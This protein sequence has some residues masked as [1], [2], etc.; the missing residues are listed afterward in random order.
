M[1]Y[2]VHS[3]ACNVINTNINM[4]TNTNAPSS[5]SIS[6]YSSSLWETKEPPRVECSQHIATKEWVVK[7]IAQA[8]CGDILAAEYVVL[9]VLSRLYSRE[10]GSLLLGSLSLSLCGCEQGDARV[11]AFKAVL[12]EI[13]PLCVQV[14]PVTD[15]RH[16]SVLCNTV[17]QIELLSFLLCVRYQQ[18]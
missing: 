12:S 4:N 6:Q 18:I 7:R 16:C 10:D 13:V 2:P 1:L 8:L 3:K 5:S 11:A 17:A 9:A 14:R 15:T